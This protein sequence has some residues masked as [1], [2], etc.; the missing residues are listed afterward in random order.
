M[1]FGLIEINNFRGIKQARLDNLADINIFIGKN[2]TGKS[3]ILEAIYLV[4]S[5]FTYDWVFYPAF[6]R[7]IEKR[8]WT[9]ERF[10]D[11]CEEL[12][13]KYERSPI[14]KVDKRAF[15]IE[16]LEDTHS[17]WFENISR[18]KPSFVKR[19]KCVTFDTFENTTNEWYC[20]QVVW[21][22][23]NKLDAYVL[24]GKEFKD[25]FEKEVFRKTILVDESFLRDLKQTAKIFEKLVDIRGY[26]IKSDLLRGL[27]RKYPQIMDLDVKQ[28][29]LRLIFEDFSITLPSVADG[30][31]SCLVASMVTCIL[32]NGVLC[33]EEPEN[34]L[35]PSLQKLYA[36]YIVSSA[37]NLKNQIF[38]STH[39]LEFLNYLLKEAQRKNVTLHVYHFLDLKDGKLIYSL[40]KRDDALRAVEEIGIDV[41]GR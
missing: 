3:A 20:S 25:E 2:S 8:G 30:I 26:K 37:K 41:R 29:V 32:D 39:S 33:F 15:R 21:V 6:V 35:H 38:I 18:T 24:H 34:H 22:A 12:K 7:I 16:V 31:K 23:E 10:E 11:I 4:S 13:F 27:R 1:R 9:L 14:I 17:D 28:N 19:K 5:N 36:S 40:Y